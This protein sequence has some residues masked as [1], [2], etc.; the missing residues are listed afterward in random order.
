MR[1]LVF[2]LS[3]I[4]DALMFTPALELLRRHFPEAQVDVLAMFPGV[5]ELYER[6]PHVQRVY[7]WEFLRQPWWRS[8]RYVLGLRR[9]RYE[10]TINVY[11]ANRW[12]YNVLSFLVG[13]PLRL[14]HTYRR[15]NWRELNWLNNRRILE[16]DHLHN[17]VEN[18]RLVE[19]LGVPLPPQLPPLRLYFEPQDEEVAERWFAV[20]GISAEAYCVGMH[21]GS[22][23]FK[24]HIRR[25][26]APE[27]F[28]ELAERLIV[29]WDA[30]VLLFG[31]ERELNE[32]IRSRCRFPRR[33]LVVEQPSLLHS[34]A[35]MRRCRLFVSNDS[36]LMHVAAALRLPTVAIFAYT[37]PAYVHP[38]QTPHRIVRKELPCSPCFYYSPRP[39]RCRWSGAD[40]FQCIRTITVEEVWAACQEL[41]RVVEGA[42]PLCTG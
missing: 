38:W 33:C 17:V 11:P 2:A 30:F 24:N 32:Y 19:L 26:W 25:R 41:R 31:T 18:A 8:L 16:E 36:A 27:R 7:L 34:A 9:Q 21:A 22:A 1:V 14:G 28:A 5:K 40:A 3:G 10:V 35:I 6:N 4:G 29:E 15:L 20:Q 39:A 23:T 13:A 12:E 42:L 37:N